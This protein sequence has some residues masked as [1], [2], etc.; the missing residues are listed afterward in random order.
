M[1][2]VLHI[3][4]STDARSPFAEWVVQPGWKGKVLTG[5]P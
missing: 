3:P 4:E 1:I 5:C 2:T